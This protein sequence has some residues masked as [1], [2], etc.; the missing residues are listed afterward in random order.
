MTVESARSPIVAVENF[1]AA[2]GGEIILHDVSFTVQEGEILV[3]LGDSGSGKSTLLK[4]MIGLYRP[5][6][7]RIL[8]EGRDLW[9]ARGRERLEILRKIGV[10]YQ[11]SA[12]FGAMTLLQNTRLPLEESSALPEEAIDLVARLKLRIVGLEGY[13]DYFPSEVSGGMQKRA[14]LARALALDP[15]LIFLDEPSAGLDP[16]TSASLDQLL[17]DL[18]G[19]LGLTF[20]VV[21]HELASIFAI[22]TRVIVLDRERKTMVA[23]GDPCELRDHGKDEWVRRFLGRDGRKSRIDA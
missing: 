20:V 3:I 16:L 5:A 12:L 18:A 2:Y 6:S 11:G 13:E 4:H 23:Q 14:A 7:G 10:T 1:A 22:A 19:T 17:M 8:I 9:Q 21:S 15:R